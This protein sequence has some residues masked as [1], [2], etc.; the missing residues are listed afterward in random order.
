MLGNT[1]LQDLGFEPTDKVVLFHCDDVGVSHSTIPAY[2]DLLDF[3]IS[4]SGSVM[5]PCP[6]FPE[7]AKLCQQYPD[8]DMGV[9]LTL[10][11][12]WQSYRW[13]PISTCDPTSG[14]ID[15]SGYMH[16]N[17]YELW[18]YADTQAIT[19]EVN[20]QLDRALNAGIQV[21][22]LD[23]HMFSM[24]SAKTLPIFNKLAIERNLPQFVLSPEYFQNQDGMTKHLNME[25]TDQPLTN[26]YRSV[27]DHAS[28]HAKLG[29]PCFDHWASLSY[30][31]PNNRVDQ[32]KQQLSQL[33]S[34][35]TFFLLHPAQES[36]ELKAIC[37]GVDWQIR[38]ADYQAMLSPDLKNYIH[39]Q[40]IKLIS[41]KQIK[42]IIESKN[43]I[44]TKQSSLV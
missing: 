13:A 8:L 21:S 25:H 18:R 27:Y 28:E 42:A 43:K 35:V 1:L 37:P 34:G 24:M 23:S 44:S 19:S 12:E 31:D 4:Q 14:L 26:K 32:L 30:T 11:N 20:A 7:V 5:V 17:E 41:F 29:M 10:T 38:V 2:Q 15:K 9:H 6:W 40:G 39:R 36:D 16:K 33:K 3:G 22:H